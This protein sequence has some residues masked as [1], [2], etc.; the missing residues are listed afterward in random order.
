MR[1][2]FN[3]VLVISSLILVSVLPLQAEEHKE[4]KEREKMK[5]FQALMEESMAHAECSAYI[6][7][8]Y[9][10]YSVADFSERLMLKKLKI[11]IFLMHN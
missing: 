4:F 10:D 5:E 2:V 7:F 3:F 6:S 1:A 9:K 11:N 8:M